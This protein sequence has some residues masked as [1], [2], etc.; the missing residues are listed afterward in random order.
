M[1]SLKLILI[2][3]Q[4]GKLKKDRSDFEREI[5]VGARTAGASVTKIAKLGI[6][7]MVTLTKMTSAVRSMGMTTIKDDNCCRQLSFDD[8][9]ASVLVRTVRNR[10]VVSRPIHIDGAKEE[11]VSCFK[12]LGLD[13]ND[14]LT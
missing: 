8:G 3:Y 7:S 11:R 5:I 10:K 4:G 9:E 14:D 12:F 2:F 6:V 1:V 13:I